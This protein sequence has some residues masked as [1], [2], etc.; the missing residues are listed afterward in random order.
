MKFF[1]HGTND[2]YKQIYPYQDGPSSD[3]F[4][5]I[6]RGEIGATVFSIE[7]IEEGIYFSLHHFVRDVIR[8]NGDGAI[9]FTVLLE[10]NEK[11]AGI[12]IL[13]FLTLVSNHICEKYL[14]ADSSLEERLSQFYNEWSS[15][16]DE[17]Y[18]LCNNRVSRISGNLNFS[19]NTNNVSGC[20]YYSDKHELARFFDFTDKNEY[21][22][23]RR[24]YFVNSNDYG[25]SNNPLSRV[26]AIED[27][28]GK[29]KPGPTQ[30][31][32]SISS[33]LSSFTVKFYKDGLVLNSG[34][35][36]NES[37]L[38][39][40]TVTLNR[41]HKP[42]EFSGSIYSLQ[43]EGIIE[44]NTTNREVHINKNKIEGLKFE[45]IVVEL[46]FKSLD[47][48]GFECL[49]AD[50]YRISGTREEKLKSKK[51]R[52]VGEE[53][54]QQY[55]FIAKHENA[56]SEKKIFDFE[57]NKESEITFQLKE[58]KTLVI[59]KGEKFDTSNEKGKVKRKESEKAFNYWPYVLT[60]GAITVVVAIVCFFIFPPQEPPPCVDD[61]AKHKNDGWQ[62][63][64]SI[65]DSITQGKYFFK[66]VKTCSG[67]EVELV[68]L[69]DKKDGTEPND[70]TQTES[71]TNQEAG[72]NQTSGLG[73][74]STAT[75]KST[76]NTPVSGNCSIFWTKFHEPTLDLKSLKKNPDEFKKLCKE[77]QDIIND[78]NKIRKIGA[79]EGGL[80]KREK[81]SDFETLNKLIN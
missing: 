10:R 54:R 29:L 42:I 23:Y 2:G 81:I 52:L 44:L 59:E 27:L 79:M 24:F 34:S 61:V 16:V 6:R 77:A 80:S 64:T 71:S 13:D 60:G 58:K 22:S 45:E 3:I 30:W 9:S 8:D 36:I 53:L 48:D 49:N 57:R 73:Q 51:F 7:K 32:L 1:I 67:S 75:D 78:D 39:S 74:N 62:E 33:F 14:S 43:Q 31:K 21:D 4:Q 35:F 50:I 70:Q 38:F 41:F 19:S 26:G 37:D 17:K 66:K 63:R 76:N 40:L 55:Q 5:D 28:T 69:K 65:S 46:N 56:V 25:K 72:Q 20:V 11:L 18:E 12:D 47:E 15:Y 68:I